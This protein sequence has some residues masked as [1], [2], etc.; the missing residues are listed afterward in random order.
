MH[1]PGTHPAP[2]H[3]E[4]GGDKGLVEWD[5]T[6]NIGPYKLEMIQVLKRG[7][8]FGGNLGLPPPVAP[9]RTAF[10]IFFVNLPME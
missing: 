3:Q 6:K 7:E 1:P 8:F 10:C 5:V 4:M 2:T 9:T